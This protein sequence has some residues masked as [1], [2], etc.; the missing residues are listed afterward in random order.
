M[1]RPVRELNWSKVVCVRRK[2]KKKKR[3]RKTRI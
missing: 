3:K 1:S 2:T